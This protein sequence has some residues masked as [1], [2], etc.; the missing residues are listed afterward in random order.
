MFPLPFLPTLFLCLL[1]ARREST[2]LAE[3]MLNPDLP[4]AFRGAYQPIRRLGQGNFGTCWVVH[5]VRDVAR[6]QEP[7]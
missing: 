3:A 2:K 1:K 5:D 6:N 4:N 7:K